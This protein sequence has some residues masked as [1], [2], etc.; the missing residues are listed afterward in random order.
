[1]AGNLRILWLVAIILLLS[2]SVGS[3]QE[4]D[5]EVISDI[6]GNYNFISAD[7]TLGLLEEEGKLK[8]Y[9]EVMQGEEESDAVLSYDI[10]SGTRKHDHVEF[11]TN[12]IH[13]TFY[14]FSGKVERGS[15]HGPN[16]PDYLHLYGMLEIVTVRSDKTEESIE[17]KFL[18]FKSTGTSEPDTN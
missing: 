14:R 15:G 1:M 18:V 7:D 4:H 16:E 5:T 17:R 2:P 3:S 10:V 11:R 13:R 12:I 9:I 6:S 8:G